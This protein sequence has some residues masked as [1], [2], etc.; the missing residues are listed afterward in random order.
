MTGADRAQRR[1]LALAVSSFWVLSGGDA[2]EQ[3]RSRPVTADLTPGP[4]HPRPL[5]LFRLS[6]LTLLLAAIAAQ[7]LPLSGR[8]SAATWPG[9]A[10]LSPPDHSTTVHAA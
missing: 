2:A 9:D 8:P 1:R 4:R 5:R 7:P 3:D 6:L 10:A